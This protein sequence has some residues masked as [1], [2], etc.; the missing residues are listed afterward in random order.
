MVLLTLGH[1]LF[2]CVVAV[3]YFR[4]VRYSR[5]TT[6]FTHAL[7]GISLGFSV[8]AAI[9]ALVMF[10]LALHHKA[11]D[12]PV[13]ILYVLTILKLVPIMVLDHI[14][15]RTKEPIPSES[16]SSSRDENGH[17]VNLPMTE[18]YIK[19]R[20]EEPIPSESRKSAEHQSGP[21]SRFSDDAPRP[22]ISQNCRAFLKHSLDWLEQCKQSLAHLLT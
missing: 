2:V 11:I 7:F 22:S 6:K 10:I 16:L 3:H 8:V 17:S 20:T 15:D 12:H 5:D 14:K 1:L 9:Y 18:H 4:T 19:D 21:V 13:V